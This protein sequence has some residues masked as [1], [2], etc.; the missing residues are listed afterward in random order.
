MATVVPQFASGVAPL[1]LSRRQVLAQFRGLITSGIPL[2]PAGRAKRDPSIPLTSRYLPKHAVTLLN[3]TYYLTD[4]YHIEDL[5][6]FVAHVF[7]HGRTTYT[8]RKAIYP[9]IFY[10]DS[11]LLWRVASHIIDTPQE[12]WIGKGDLVIEHL[13]DGDFVASVESSTNLPYEAQS[14]FDEISRR[15]TSRFE[16][17]ALG[18]ILRNAPTGRMAPYADFHT[19]VTRST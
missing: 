8:R 17:R 11:S 9:R 7:T 1:V 12:Q 14:A 3:V 4:F 16:P 13:P 6:F 10:K 15:T 5:N 2:L 18:L 19:Q